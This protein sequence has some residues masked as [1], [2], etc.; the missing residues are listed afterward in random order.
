RSARGRRL[1]RPPHLLQDTAQR[2]RGAGN[3]GRAECRDAVAGQT[4]RNRRDRI[5][6]L[7]R[8]DTLDPMNV[9]VNKAGKDVMPVEGETGTLDGAWPDVHDAATIDDQ[10]AW[11][12]DAV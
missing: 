2:L 4:R 9:H 3:G 5:T 6:G 8:I 10:G 1:A 7:Q 12:Q 11:R